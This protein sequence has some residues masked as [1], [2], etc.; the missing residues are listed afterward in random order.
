M[1]PERK[2]RGPT[3]EDTHREVQE[4][5]IALGQYNLGTIPSLP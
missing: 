1:D 4:L 3:E 5:A 2:Q